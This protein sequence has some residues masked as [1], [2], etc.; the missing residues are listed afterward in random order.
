MDQPDD[1]LL[2][3]MR[4]P[5]AAVVVNQCGREGKRWIQR[6][7]GPVCWIDS[8]ERGL[9][10][11]RNLALANSSAE[12]CLLADDDEVF[13]PDLPQIIRAAFAREPRMDI[14]QFQVEGIEEPFR[15]YPAAPRRR[16]WLGINKCASVEIAFRRAA[17][18]RAELRFDERFGSGAQYKMGEETLFLWQ[19]VCRRLRVKYLPQRIAWLHIGQSSWFTGY[20]RRYF[21]DKGAN[22]AAMGRLV[23]Y[24]LIF[25]YAVRKHSL[26]QERDGVYRV[27]HS[28]LAGRRAYLD[29]Q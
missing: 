27:L 15:Q 14:L 20:N 2:D 16:R 12:L 18:V 3:R 13:C 23:S 19:C 17:I 7:A 26:S 28:M 24:G 22:F 29:A 6:S 11:S 9:S 4:L 1:S 21:F 25:Q 10:K 5:C 8:A